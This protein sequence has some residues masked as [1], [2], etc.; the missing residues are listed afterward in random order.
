VSAAISFRLVPVIFGSGRREVWS[1]KTRTLFD[2]S[3][4][5]T[6]HPRKDD[7]RRSL[8]RRK[9]KRLARMTA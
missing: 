6:I 2:G 4:M 8:E 3:I 7:Q 5:L 9:L 1:L